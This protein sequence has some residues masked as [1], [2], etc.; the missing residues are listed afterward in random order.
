MRG[1]G[2]MAMGLLF[3]TALQAQQLL[4]HTKMDL[5]DLA[6]LGLPSFVG[7]TPRSPLAQTPEG[8]TARFMSCAV[9]TNSFQVP[10]DSTTVVG[11][12]LSGG[13][14]TNL[15][16]GF[17]PHASN[18][19]FTLINGLSVDKIFDIDATQ[20]PATITVYTYHVPANGS[21]QVS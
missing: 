16:I 21:V 6:P 5:E 12:T 17:S 7:A 10:G 20:P 11:T 19:K 14:A 4:T 2:V 13:F 8:A 9:L 18:L 15:P 1:F 3:A